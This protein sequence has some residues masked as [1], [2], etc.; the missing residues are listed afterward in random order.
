[1]SILLHTQAVS[2]LLE[3]MSRE[4][5]PTTGD[6]TIVRTEDCVCKSN[7]GYYWGSWCIEWMGDSWLPQPYHRESGYFATPEEAQAWSE[8]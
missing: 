7:A 8:L 4:T 3:A 6:E 1:M 5:N 2:S